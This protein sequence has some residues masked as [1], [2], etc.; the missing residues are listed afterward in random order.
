MVHA[1]LKTSGM[2][3][4]V[5]QHCPTL[6]N[7][8]Q[9]FQ[10][11]RQATLD[12]F[13]IIHVEPGL[14]PEPSGAELASRREQVSVM[15]ARIAACA[16]LMDCQIDRDIVTIGQFEGKVAR[17]LQALRCCQLGRKT[18]QIFTRYPRIAAM[19]GSFGRVP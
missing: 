19:L 16:G 5:D 12:S 1:L 18:D 7:G 4:L 9:L 13:G 10:S 17:E 6:T 15:I 11:S 3:S 2:K 8:H 14:G